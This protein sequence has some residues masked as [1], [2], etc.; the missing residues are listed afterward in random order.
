VTD[1]AKYRKR[2]VLVEA[3]RFTNESK[4]ACFSWVR[5]SGTRYAYAAHGADDAP[6]LVIPTLEGDMRAKVG[7]WIIRGVQGEHYPCKPDIFEATYEVVT[8]D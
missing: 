6:E 3:M 1:P 8:D 4:D 7:D 2:P 5:A